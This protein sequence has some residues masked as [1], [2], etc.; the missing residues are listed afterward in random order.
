MC[1]YLS[2]SLSLS[3]N[4]MPVLYIK[5]TCKTNNVLICLETSGH[6]H[7]NSKISRQRTAEGMHMHGGDEKYI[8]NRNVTQRLSH[9]DPHH[10]CV[11]WR[12]VRAFCVCAVYHDPTE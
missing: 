11:C 4:H 9:H 3:L 1:M 6:D 7:Q 10:M 5:S 8:R 12:A 2:L